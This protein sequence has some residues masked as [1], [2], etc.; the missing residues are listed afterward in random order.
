M[1]KAQSWGR[2]KK[3]LDSIST[4]NTAFTLYR[5][6]PP[7]RVTTILNQLPFPWPQARNKPNMRDPLPL[8]VCG[9]KSL[10]LQLCKKKKKMEVFGSSSYFL[11]LSFLLSFLV[12]F[13]TSVH[14][15]TLP[16]SK[17]LSSPLLPS[18]TLLALLSWFASFS[19]HSTQAILMV[20]DTWHLVSLVSLMP[21]HTP[22]TSMQ[23]T[24]VTLGLQWS[25]SQVPHGT[26]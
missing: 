11:F 14:E 2:R 23:P 19:S 20:Q 3:K 15:L 5:K 25:I 24:E 13:L 7:L 4:K 10:I 8:V 9:I 26:L 16:S 21:R 18:R 22:L 1:A 17:T 6:S 12:S